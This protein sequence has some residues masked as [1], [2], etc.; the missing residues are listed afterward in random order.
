MI[1]V[2]EPD[3]TQEQ[4]EA[5]ARKVGELG[6]RANVIV[7]TERTVIAVVGEERQHAKEL[8]EVSDGVATVMRRSPAAVSRPAVRRSA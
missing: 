4:I 2:M 6:L 5:A 3:A 1:V 8:L 7:G